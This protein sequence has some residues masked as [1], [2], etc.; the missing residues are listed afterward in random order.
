MPLEFPIV[1]NNSNADVAFSLIARDRQTAEWR[2]IT[3]SNPNLKI[4][5]ITKQQV[6]GK[7]PAGHPIRRSLVQVRAK[8]PV[9]GAAPG[10]SEEVVVN[11]TIVHPELLASTGISQLTVDDLVAYVRNIC[12]GANVQKLVQGQV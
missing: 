7:S 6:V 12:S 3:N 8:S 9:A 4:T 10:A 2:E 11:M 1:K 5:A